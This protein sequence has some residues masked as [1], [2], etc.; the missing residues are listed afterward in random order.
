VGDYGVDVGGEGG[1]EGVEGVNDDL[2][3][4]PEEPSL[5][6][7]ARYY[8]PQS[9]HSYLGGRNTPRPRTP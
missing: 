9:P 8:R 7:T 6:K 5:I 2:M 3:T 4:C 1:A